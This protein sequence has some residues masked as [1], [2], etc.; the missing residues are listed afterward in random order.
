MVLLWIAVIIAFVGLVQ[1][2]DRVRR[3]EQTADD[4]RRTIERL[5]KRLEEGVAPV[6]ARA[7]TP[8]PV[9]RYDRPPAVAPRRP[10]E[11]PVAEE[12]E[13]VEEETVEEEPVLDPAVLAGLAQLNPPASRAPEPVTV[14]KETA[15]SAR[16]EPDRPKRSFDWEALI[17][18]KLFAIIAS[19]ALF[20]A[21][22]FFVSYSMEH[23]WL[24]PTIQFAIGIVAG[25]TCLVLGELKGSRRYA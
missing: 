15:A 14:A 10:V 19:L 12:K 6:A 11:E 7:P 24:T 13:S 25:V 17:G 1:L 20:L 21:G 23:G 9:A 2:L 8:K 22:G 4:L 5:T 16:P 3:L 18:V